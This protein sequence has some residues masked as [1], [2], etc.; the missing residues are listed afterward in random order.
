VKRRAL[1]Q[2][3]P[4]LTLAPATATRAQGFPDIARWTALVK[5]QNLR[6]D[7]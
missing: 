7:A 2:P 4:A 1:L 5:A 6:I 3:V